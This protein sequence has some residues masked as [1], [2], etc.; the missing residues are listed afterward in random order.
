VRR[1]A[2]AVLAAALLAGCG[3]SE[4]EPEPTGLEQMDA[5]W[6]DL[7]QQR[8]EDFCLGLAMFG[9]EAAARLADVEDVSEADL[10][11]WMEGKCE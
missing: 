9:T 10:A 7:D 4:P 11:A 1:L 8:R 6:A 3:G 2:V 5:L